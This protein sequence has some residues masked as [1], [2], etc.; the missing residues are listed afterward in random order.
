MDRISILPGGC[1]SLSDTVRVI[2]VDGRQLP[3]M[4]IAEAQTLAAQQRAELIHIATGRERIFRLAD[5]A[6]H[7]KLRRK[8]R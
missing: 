4:T 3:L 7:A 6:L 5:E 2:G 1:K 8:Q